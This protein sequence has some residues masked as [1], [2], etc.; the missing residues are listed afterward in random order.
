MKKTDTIQISGLSAYIDNISRLAEH[1]PDYDLSV[2]ELADTGRI[3]ERIFESAYNPQEIELKEQ[4][5]AEGSDEPVRINVIAD[6]EIIGT[7]LNRQVKGVLTLLES[8]RPYNV[9]LCLQGGRYKV[10][11]PDS[12]D[13][14]CLQCEEAGLYAFLTL[15]YDDLSETAAEGSSQDGSEGRSYIST[16]Y[17]TSILK[18]DPGKKGSLLLTLALIISGSYLI[19]SGLYWYFIRSGKIAPLSVLGGDLPGRLLYPHLGIAGAGTIF[20]VL[21]MLTKNS[22]FPLLGGCAFAASGIFLPGYT[23]FTVL[24]AI[25]AA[26]ASLSR[27]S[28]RKALTFLKVLVFLAVLGSCGWFLKNTVMNV[29]NG[30]SFTLLP[31]WDSVPEGEAGNSEDADIGLGDE[32][33]WDNEAGWDDDFY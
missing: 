8:K 12:D 14:L 18:E 7:V 25:F 4:Q 29:Y 9:S 16:S 2:K 28:E 33:D 5:P 11:L 24:P 27:K 20:I 3:G 1:N 6:G 32:A 17:E 21:A 15:E 10:L 31:A 22:I 26:G 30:G 13:E 19:F 23:V